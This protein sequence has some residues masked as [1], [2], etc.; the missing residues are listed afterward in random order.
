MEVIDC[1]APLNCRSC[2][3]DTLTYVS[4]HRPAPTLMR[5]VLLIILLVL[6]LN[7]AAQVI[8]TGA[9]DPID[10]TYIWSIS[11]GGYLDSYYAF[12]F[13][14]PEDGYRPYFV[15]MNHHNE[16]AINLGYIDFKFTSPRVRARF[17]PGFGTYV[18]ENYAH[19]PGA[20]RNLIE[21]SVGI[22]LFKD[23][24]IWLDAGVMGSPYTNESAISR[25]QLT[26]T[27]SFAPEY[28]PY[29]LTGIKLLIPLTSRLAG[30]IYLLNGWQQIRDQNRNKAIG[31]Q[32]EFRPNETVIISWS[33]FFGKEGNGSDTVS[34]VIGMRYFSDVYVLYNN[35]RW[36]AASSF[37]AG[38][39]EREHTNALWWQWNAAARYDLSS[40][41]SVTGRI[42]Y[43]QD[44]QSV[45][46]VPIT[47]AEGFRSSG[48]S[49]GLN[50]KLADN[51]LLRLEGR[52]FF[53]EEAVYLRDGPVKTSNLIASN[54]SI[55]F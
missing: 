53:S 6:S 27:R 31:T 21:A 37:Y 46:I 40:R 48:A 38:M 41:L 12:D 25:D 49:V 42:E 4:V 36:S 45:M 26:Y 17:A 54:I 28:V 15:S 19:E 32:L 30:S 34:S 55:W 44:D 51:V 52:T 20:L 23:R 8:I 35:N 5:S 11:L 24:D 16:V 10:S 39:Q 2:L 9:K 43:F 13:N 3:T 18:D 7:A 1:S 47:E 14:K 22:K 33:T 50:F 29:Y